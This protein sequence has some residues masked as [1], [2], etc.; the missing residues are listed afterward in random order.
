MKPHQQLDSLDVGIAE[1]GPV[2]RPTFLVLMTFSVRWS[3][4][5]G[6][7]R[8]SDLVVT[9]VE[10]VAIAVHLLLSASRAWWTTFT[11]RLTRGRAANEPRV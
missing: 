9:P 10:A 6:G 5:L 8:S 11:Q 7:P 2:G 3:Q 4:R 1:T